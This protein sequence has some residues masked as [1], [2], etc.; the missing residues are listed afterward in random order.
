MMMQRALLC[1]SFSLLLGSAPI[2][3]LLLGGTNVPK[4]KIIVYLLIGHSNMAGVD[5]SK[6][7]D[8][9]HP[10]CWN[11]PIKTN[12]WV[13]AK[14]PKNNRNAGLSG[15]GSAGPGMPFLKGMAAA[16]PDYYFG[17]IS[18][19][20]LSSTCRG[21]NT[22]NNTSP[23]DASD[24]RYWD[25]TYLYNQIV[26]AAKSVQNDVTLGGI[27][28]MLGTVDATR[29]TLAVC[30]NF[31]NDVSELVRDMRRDLG[32]PNLPFIMGEY[33]AGATRDFSPTLPMPAAVASEIKLIPSKLPFSAT[34]N[35]VG[36]TMLDDHHYSGDKGQPEFAKRTI[37]LIQSNNFFPSGGASIAMP[38]GKAKLAGGTQRGPWILSATGAELI[39][40]GDGAYLL[41]GRKGIESPGQAG[42]IGIKAP[43]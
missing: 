17:V 24:N 21:I 42:R 43:R 41:N 34:V 37:A 10:H 31:S 1:I 19:A 8:V 32:M 22:G 13:L 5:A 26:N 39:G 4:E 2:H 30:Q 11:Y 3:A 12:T 38:A 28:C 23:L 29:T 6:S 20:S 25:S 14:E 18:N 27:I 35:S 40:F 16:Y 9:T 7:D 15:T 33:E 36:I